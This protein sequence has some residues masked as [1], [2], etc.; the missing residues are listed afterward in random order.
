MRFFSFTLRHCNV[1]NALLNADV[2][3]CYTML[4]VVCSELSTFLAI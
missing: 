4:N 1:C 2:H 3:I